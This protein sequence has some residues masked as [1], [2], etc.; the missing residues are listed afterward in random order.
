MPFI[1]GFKH[2]PQF[3]HGSLV[4]MSISMHCSIFVSINGM[5]VFWW[6]CL[7]HLTSSV[8]HM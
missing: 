1:I 2:M 7:H 3:K 6:L 5:T 8:A 4:F